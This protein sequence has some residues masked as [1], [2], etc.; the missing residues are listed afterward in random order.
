M[1]TT[2]RKHCSSFSSTQFLRSSKR[3]TAGFTLIELMITIAIV[4]ILAA[5]AIPSYI[6]YSNK[7]RFA[8]VVQAVSGM[9]NAVAAC[10]VSTATPGGTVS[11]C[12]NGSN[13][14]PAAITNA[15]GTASTASVTVAASGAI[16]GT[17]Q[18]PAPTATYI[19]TPTYRA[20]GTITW[21][22]TGTCQAQGVC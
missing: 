20:N 1:R 2:Y 21:A 10:I 8:E 6:N 7:A 19:L 16:T 12:A 11:T 5:V 4:G 18:A 22:A 13:G 14:V 17:G 9:K 3:Q 15:S